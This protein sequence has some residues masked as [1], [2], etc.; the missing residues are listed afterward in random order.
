MIQM[1]LFPE[2]QQKH[3][4]TEQTFGHGVRGREGKDGREWRD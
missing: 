4:H 3:R 2:Q 1:N